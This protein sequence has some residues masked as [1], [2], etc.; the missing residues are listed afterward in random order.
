M[1]GYLS[2]T[3]DSVK[4]IH[5]LMI[6][7]GIIGLIHI[8]GLIFIITIF[9]DIK[10]NIINDT[11]SVT[12]GT[13]GST[14]FGLAKFACILLWASI[15]FEFAYV[16]WMAINR[17]SGFTSAG[18]ILLYT[19][20]IALLSAQVIGMFSISRVVFRAKENR[21]TIKDD[22]NTNV[23]K[24]LFTLPMSDLDIDIGKYT[25]GSSVLT[26]LLC[27]YLLYSVYQE[28]KHLL[29]YSSSGTSF[30]LPTQGSKKK[31]KL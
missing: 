25:A 3:P 19:F 26:T 24:T 8:I 14:T 4:A 23:S 7:G 28:K 16:V 11:N 15:F 17:P 13:A 5:L 21:V 10:R 29:E 20:V 6:I 22:D 27:V 12:F 9:F 18:E 2:E 30:E 1:K 31:N